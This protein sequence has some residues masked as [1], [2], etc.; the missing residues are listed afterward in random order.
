MN[1]VIRNGALVTATVLA[2]GLASGAYAAKGDLFTPVQGNTSVPPATSLQGHGRVTVVAVLAG[3][4]I[5][6]VQ[7]KAGRRLSQS[8]IDTVGQ[9]RA[10]AAAPAIGRIQQLGGQVL[11]TFHGAL[12]GVKVSIPANQLKALRAVPGVVDVKR[13]G[14]Y[15]RSNATSVPL[16][17]APLV[18]QGAAHLQG[19]A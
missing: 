1:T 5:A 11:N 15:E 4:S 7:G 16:I 10:L 17:G 12:N 8:E 9:A 14:T 13:V 6:I 3:D 19:Q 18:W 2:L